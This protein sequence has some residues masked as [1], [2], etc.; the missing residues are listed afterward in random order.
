[1]STAPGNQVPAPKEPQWP[2]SCGYM[3]VSL[4]IGALAGGLL[5][6]LG[7]YIGRPGIEG[8]GPIDDAN[9]LGWY[10]SCFGVFAAPVVALIVYWFRFYQNKAKHQRS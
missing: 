7:G 3:L 5:G 9:F 8:G 10:C 2:P 4:F 6:V 1:M